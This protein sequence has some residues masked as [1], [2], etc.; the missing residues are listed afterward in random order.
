MKVLARDGVPCEVLTEAGL[1]SKL[2]YVVSKM[3][4]FLLGCW[5]EGL[6]S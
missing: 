4:P 1:T 5:I 3:I 2:T 6:S